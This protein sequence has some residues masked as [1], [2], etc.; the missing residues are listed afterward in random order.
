MGEGL[1]VDV[2]NSN[3]ALSQMKAHTIVVPWHGIRLSKLPSR[4]AKRLQSGRVR[5]AKKRLKIDE[6]VEGIICWGPVSKTFGDIA[7]DRLTRLYDSIHSDG[8][9]ADN[10]RDP[11]KTFVL[12]R[13]NEYCVMPRSGKH[14]VA[15][16]SALDYQ[17][18]PVLMGPS[19]QV[20]LVRREEVAA[21]PHVV[22]GL[23]TPSDALVVFDRIFEARPPN[24]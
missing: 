23:F 10:F 7:F 11:M 1:G 8:F 4:A 21:W 15:V 3:A 24:Q 2:Q 12:V 5:D 6:P 14:R 19:P 18:I 22:S 17:E 13:N 16:L 9:A 20:M